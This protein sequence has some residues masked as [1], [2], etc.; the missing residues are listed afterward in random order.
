M[1]RE[2]KTLDELKAIVLGEIRQLGFPSIS[3]G[4]I[5]RVADLRAD[6][7]WSLGPI[8]LGNEDEKS[9][10]RAVGLILRC[11]QDRYELID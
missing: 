1:Y 8:A 3:D 6:F 2:G 5:Y 9:V 10:L 7:N 4:Q 11:L